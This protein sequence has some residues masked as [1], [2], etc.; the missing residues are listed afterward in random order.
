MSS[1][2]QQS[3]FNP[4]VFL[5]ALGAGGIAVAPFAI[6]QYIFPHSAGLITLFDVLNQ[7]LN[8][9]QNIFLWFALVVMPVFSIIHFVLLFRFIPALISF[10][11]YNLKQH[12]SDP[13]QSPALVIPILALTMSMNV[14]IG[15]I[16]FFIPLV[17]INFQNLM[18]PALVF[19]IVLLVTQFTLQIK[20]LQ[21]TY[22]KDFAAEKISFNWLV[23]ALSMG[24]LSVVGSGIA[25]LAKDITIMDISGFLSLMAATF[26]IFLTFIGLTISVFNQIFAKS[27]P[28]NKSL[29]AFLNLVPVTTV[30]AI[31][32]FRLGHF[33]EN[34]FHYHLDFFLLLVILSTF[35]FQT[36]YL[37]F[38]IG[39][40]KPFWKNDFLTKNFYL[41]QWSLICPFVA[42]AVLGA[43]ASAEFGNNQFIFALSTVSLV[44]GIV[45]YAVLG[46]KAINYSKTQN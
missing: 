22:T 41:T 29:P 9:Y 43:F 31:T 11:K 40:I 39:L 18:W 26:A 6:M 37:I 19:W 36:W 3:Q 32:F 7:N 12:L 4:Q 44:A 34:R 46:F 5:A 2:T 8:I 17:Q 27:L 33:V 28:E 42:Y 1:S 10:I 20:I 14:F 15:V 30:L 24:M 45:I 38:S 13:L 23:Q 16:R 21:N 25:A 35:A